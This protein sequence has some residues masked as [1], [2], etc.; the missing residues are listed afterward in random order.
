[1]TALTPAVKAASGQSGNTLDD[2]IK[3]NVLLN[4]ERL[5]NATPI[6]NKFVADGKVRVIGGV[7]QL[8]TGKVEILQ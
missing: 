2:T 4:V 5:K 7:Y 6:V 1:V 3:Q 8:D